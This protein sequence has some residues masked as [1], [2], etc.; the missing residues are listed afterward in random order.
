MNLV[1]IFESCD[2]Y[3]IQNSIMTR[4]EVC[5]HGCYGIKPGSP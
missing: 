4:K 1:P 3:F 2:T 5:L